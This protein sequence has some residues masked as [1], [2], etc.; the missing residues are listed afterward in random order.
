LDGDYNLNKGILRKS[1]FFG[2]PF[3]SIF[4]ETAEQAQNVSAPFTT[5]S[6]IYKGE[7]LTKEILSEKKF[8][9]IIEKG[10]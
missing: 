2:I 1:I 6:L 9:K 8:E 5:Y 4:F 3:K 7:F 10:L